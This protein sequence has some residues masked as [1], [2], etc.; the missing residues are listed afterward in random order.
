MFSPALLSLNVHLRGRSG[1]TD[2]VTG[3]HRSYFGK[4]AAIDAGNPQSD[5]SN[6]PSPNGKR[7]NL[8]VYGNTPYA[9]R[10]SYA[11][12]IIIVR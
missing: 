10:S 9:T 11:G 7:V 1:Y 8:G 4:S 2:E 5:Y 3:E 12:F 6:E